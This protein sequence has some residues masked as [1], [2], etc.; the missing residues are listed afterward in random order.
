MSVDARANE[1]ERANNA[2]RTENQRL[3]YEKDDLVKSRDD[4]RTCRVEYVVTVDQIAFGSR[5]R[6][7]R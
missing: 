1:L 5:L 3:V 7:A 2:A 6:L 4:A